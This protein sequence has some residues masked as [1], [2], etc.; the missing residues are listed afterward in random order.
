MPTKAVATMNSGLN[1]YLDDKPRALRS[2]TSP[3]F[4]KPLRIIHLV[5]EDSPQL[6]CAVQELVKATWNNPRIDALL[7]SEK[8]LVVPKIAGQKISPAIPPIPFKQLHSWSKAGRALEFYRL[9]RDENP[10]AVFIHHQ[11]FNNRYRYASLRAR[12]KHI[13]AGSCARES[14]QQFPYGISLDPFAKADEVP[15]NL[16]I[17]GII[18]PSGFEGDYHRQ[19]IRAVSCLREVRLYP[20]I[21]LTGPGSQRACEDAQQLCNA[22]GLENQVRVAHHC[23]NLPFLLMHHQLAVI[24]QPAREQILVAQAMAAGSVTI[25]LAQSDQASLIQHNQDGILFTDESPELFAEQLQALLTNATESQRLADNA[26]IRALQEFS[27]QRM[28]E[29]YHQVYRG[30]CPRD[31]LNIDLNVDEVA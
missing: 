18:M 4:T 15:L 10:D 3:G 30:L 9:C 28:I 26:R 16:R 5:T 8:P 22:L 25:G 6:Q 12:V 24:A 2:T 19:L 7:V 13:F 14:E 31:D 29:N 11:E 1:P 23:S 27:L 17:P 21:F 20:R